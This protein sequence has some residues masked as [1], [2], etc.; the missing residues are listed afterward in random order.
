MK[1]ILLILLVSLFI[2]SL[3]I[4]AMAKVELTFWAYPYFNF[5]DKE[6]GSLESRIISEFEEIY[7][8]VEITLEM[9][10][11]AGDHEKI[12]M[13]IVTGTGPDI[14]QH[15]DVK[16]MSYAASGLL[17]DFEDTIDAEEKADYWPGVLETA[18]WDGKVYSCLISADGSPGMEVNRFVVEKADAM[19]LL[20][21]NNENRIWASLEDFKKFCLKIADAKI[22]DTYAFAL[23]F[24]DSN[25]QHSYIKWMHRTFGAVP[26][27]LEDGKYRCTMNSPES[28]EGLGW[29]LD[30][31]NTPGV[32][33]PG[34]ES[35]G[36]DFYTKYWYG[37]NLAFTMAGGSL[38]GLAATRNDPIVAKTCDEILVAIPTKE[39]IKPPTDIG[40]RTLGVFKSTPEKEKFAKLFCEFYTTR[41]YLWEESKMACPPRFS[42]FDPDSPM[43]QTSPFPAGDTEVEYALKWAD[44]M[45]VIDSFT[46]V[47][48]YQQY[49]STYASIMQ[50]VFSGELEPKEGLD[51]LTEKIN[52][53]LDEYYEEFPVK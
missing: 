36:V 1:K 38:G 28:I 7:P 10:S 4:T 20:P 26:F 9:L 6:S 43:Y 16:V 17:S 40:E 3:A 35:M 32:G 11:S 30:L 23:H 18:M 44:Y 39:G 47:P 52:K 8:D 41:P 14:L 25:C 2:F 45:Q 13:A 21:L 29:Y 49:R 37:G 12:E 34:P 15:G 51:I 31:Y 50:G 33:M 46:K 42:S 27:V 48:V 24:M 5:E 22:P 53:L 19:D